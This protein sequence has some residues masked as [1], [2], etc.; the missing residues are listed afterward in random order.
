[1]RTLGA[2]GD[3][4]RMTDGEKHVGFPCRK[5]ETRY[6]GMFGGGYFRI[7]APFQQLYLVVAGMS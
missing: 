5:S 4:E 3:V 6:A 7:D 2:G 1:M